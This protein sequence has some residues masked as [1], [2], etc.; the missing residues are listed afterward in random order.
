MNVGFFSRTFLFKA[1]CHF[2]GEWEK[3][4]Q[5]VNY[6]LS[7]QKKQ[8]NINE[9]RGIFTKN[10]KTMNDAELDFSYINTCRNF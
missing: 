1:E 4:T 9:D 2:K 8:V 10:E 7:F 6:C 3:C 5:R